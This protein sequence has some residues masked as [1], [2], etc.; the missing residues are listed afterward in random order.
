MKAQHLPGSKI[1]LAAQSPLASLEKCWF[2][3]ADPTL[4]AFIRIVV[5]CVAFY[6][7]LTWGIGLAG[8]VGPNAWIDAK[9]AHYMTQEFP[10]IQVPS[11][12]DPNSVAPPDRGFFYA[13]PFFHVTN[14]YWLWTIH[15]SILAVTLLFTIGYQTRITSVLT[16][17]GALCYFSAVNQCCSA[18]IRCSTCC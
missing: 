6:T 3:P 15:L 8:Y 1:D 9:A 11:T 2:T 7:A 12:W 13:S 4:L 5:G 17:L 18:P 16:W 10:F 14:P